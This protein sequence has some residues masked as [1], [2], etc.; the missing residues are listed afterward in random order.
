[1]NGRKKYE[2]SNVRKR[3]PQRALWKTRTTPDLRQKTKNKME[4]ESPDEKRE[5]AVFVFSPTF[6][7][8]LL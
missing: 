4:V 3:S 7:C 6:F 8:F 2:K 1:M 5:K